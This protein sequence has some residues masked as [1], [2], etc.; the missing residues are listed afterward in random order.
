[1][2]VMSLGYSV[3]EL[4]KLTV[5]AI[6]IYDTFFDKWKNAP[7]QLRS[8]RDE[9]ERCR[10]SLQVQDYIL[11]VI[12]RDYP[13]EKAFR[14]TLD[15]CQSFVDGRQR[16]IARKNG[17][18]T[19]ESIV[20]VLQNGKF[21]FERDYAAYLSNELARRRNELMEFNIELILYVIS[22]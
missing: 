21:A 7:R 3:S 2:P 13:G 4:I 5:T 17:P 11:R 6:Q 16:V 9:L 19:K 18:E 8:L 12:G 20:G 10:S 1:M 14:D 22:L 15:E